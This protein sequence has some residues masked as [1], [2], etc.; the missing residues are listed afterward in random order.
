MRAPVPSLL[1]RIARCRSGVA[2][3]EFALIGPTLMILL[4][5]LIAIG[6][7]M[8]TW[9]AMQSTAQYAALLVSTGQ[10]KSL[11]N[12]AITT[13]N[14]TATTACSGSLTSTEAE[15]YACNG[16]PGWGS[17]SVTTTEDCSVP[18]VTVSVS[19][20]AATVAIG[21]ILSLFTGRTL[22]AQSVVMKEGLCP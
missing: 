15:Y 2:S 12:G 11:S 3:I 10:V 9:T 22:S 6:T 20:N 8:Y 17:Y 4:F 7:L 18:S 16:L 13:V 19:A 21:D 14:N 1:S 5:G